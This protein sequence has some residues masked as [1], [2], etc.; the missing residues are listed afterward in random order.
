MS[1]PALF[2]RETNFSV[3]V[4]SSSFFSSQQKLPASKT[5]VKER[6]TAFTDVEI[7]DPF[8]IHFSR[9]SSTQNADFCVIRFWIQ[10]N[11]IT[12]YGVYRTVKPWS[13]FL[14]PAKV[15]GSSCFASSVV[16]DPKENS[17]KNITARNPGGGKYALHSTRSEPR[18]NEI[19]VITN[20]I[21]KNSNG[22]STT[23]IWEIDVNRSQCEQLSIPGV[24]FDGRH[25]F[26]GASQ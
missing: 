4:W 7:A 8:Q 22:K 3:C 18:C 11:W 16:R 23:N 25:I 14:S 2:Q 13:I 12:L 10:L 21:R 17:E 6:N 20:T 1:R 24:L 15:T 19:L 26:A 5:I 9:L